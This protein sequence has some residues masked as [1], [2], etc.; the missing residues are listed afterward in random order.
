MKLGV[1]V[2]VGVI[3]FNGKTAP[4]GLGL[5]GKIVRSTC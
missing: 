1:G 3:M 5:E 2:E 4:K